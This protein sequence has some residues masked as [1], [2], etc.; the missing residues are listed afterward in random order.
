MSM[1]DEEAR[2]RKEDVMII[3]YLRQ[4]QGICARH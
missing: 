4:H 3:P 1:A 2:M